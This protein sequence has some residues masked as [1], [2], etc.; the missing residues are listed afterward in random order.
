M[1]VRM[2]ARDRVKT[3]FEEYRQALAIHG[4][5]V[6]LFAASLAVRLARMPIPSQR[7]RGSIYRTIYGK[8]YARLDEA[9]LERPLV[10]YR[11]F[12]ALFTRGVRPE[13]RPISTSSHQMVC[14]CDG[15]IQDVGRFHDGKILT[16]KGVEYSLDSLLA[17]TNAEVF[18]DGRYAIIFLSPNNCH[19]IFSPCEGRLTEA[20]H[21]P[22]YRLL[23]H[24]PF[25]RNEFPVFTLNE[26]LVLRL[27]T[28]LGN[29]ALVLVAGWGVGHITLP[30]GLKFKPRSR[31]LTQ[32]AFAV[33]PT[34][35]RGEWIATFELGSTAILITDRAQ[36]VS[37][38][39][40]IGAKV[41]Y[42]Q[43]A[44]SF[45]DKEFPPSGGC[46]PAEVAPSSGG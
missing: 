20:V 28:P 4:G 5:L 44:F 26:R 29:C 33:P 10:S 1:K 13:L 42:G 35:A 38:H 17:G 12:N 9:E 21:V 2:K 24:P 39:L 14:P 11:S 31:R 23:V 15:M 37:T 7:L 43:P 3:K 30:C 34:V 46:Q 40:E 36:G 18:R 27:A 16:V 45:D 8:K 25:Q 19:R 32:R 22:G 6:K 41:K